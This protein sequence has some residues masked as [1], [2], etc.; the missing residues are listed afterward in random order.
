MDGIRKLIYF[1]KVRDI[2]KG[3]GVPVEYV[4]AIENMRWDTAEQLQDKT[5]MDGSKLSGNYGHQGRPGLVGGSGGGGGGNSVSVSSLNGKTASAIQTQY[6]L[7]QNSIVHAKQAISKA[8]GTGVKSI[9]NAQAL[10]YIQNAQSKQ[11]PNGTPKAQVIQTLTANP[12]NL[13]INPPTQIPVNSANSNSSGPVS[14]TAMKNAQ[15]Q[16]AQAQ[17]AAPTAPTAQQKQDVGHAE[18]QSTMASNEA[19]T[20]RDIAKNTR[21]LSNA[22]GAVQAA[23]DAAKQAQDAVQK[24][25][26]INK[27]TNNAFDTNLQKAQQNANV[28]KQCAQEAQQ[29]ETKLANQDAFADALNNQTAAAIQ[30]QYGLNQNAIVHAKQAVAKQ[31]GV[32]TGDITNA[33]AMYY[34]QHAQTKQNPGGMPKD[35]VCSNIN[36]NKVHGDVLDLDL[37]GTVYAGGQTPATATQAATAKAPKTASKTAQAATAASTPQQPAYGQP[38][39]KVI[40]KGVNTH[41]QDE[42]MQLPRS[43]PRMTQVLE[44]IGVSKRASDATAKKKLQE[45]FDKENADYEERYKNASPDRQK[46]MDQWQN[47]TNTQRAKMI[48]DA[49]QKLNASGLVG[50]DPGLN[51]GSLQALIYAHKLEGKPKVVKNAAEMQKLAKDSALNPDGKPIG[52][53]HRADSQKHHKALR[54]NAHYYVGDG[55]HDGGTY[56]TTRRGEYSGANMQVTFNKKAQ[57]LEYSQNASSLKG[58]T[59]SK[60]TTMALVDGYPSLF[61]G[62]SKL[63]TKPGDARLAPGSDKT[64]FVGV[65]AVANGYDGIYA[66]NGNGGSSDY[67]MACSRENMTVYIE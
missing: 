65:M 57:F 1:T 35:Q 66:R 6:G 43:D 21:S 38:G 64:A 50:K 48:A 4:A 59:K 8:T 7:K 41:R 28:A 36:D 33:Q 39:H 3:S 61:T 19:Q 5:R 20:N 52:I 22:Y 17:Q 32:K 55:L 9:T 56:M 37:Q 62:A 40:G 60:A 53:I 45:Y 47:S 51:R 58:G 11:N 46:L 25:D 14:S 42:F 34:I 44:N 16:Q 27:A 24:I 67:Y 29:A 31:L 13:Q 23:N 15:A 26:Q 10:Y 12:N 54:D 63:G 49:E 18:F 2:L 30:K